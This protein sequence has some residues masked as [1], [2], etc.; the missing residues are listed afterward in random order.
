MWATARLPPPAARAKDQTRLGRGVT[1]IVV[2]IGQP[3]RRDA[4][5]QDILQ[6]G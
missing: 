4:H 2:E 6:L 1:P 5:R 3:S